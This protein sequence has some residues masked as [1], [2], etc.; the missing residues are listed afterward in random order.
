[1]RPTYR[2][3]IGPS[4]DLNHTLNITLNSLFMNPL[5]PPPPSPPLCV[6]VM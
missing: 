5:T 6:F 2:E 4:I 3:K 1:M